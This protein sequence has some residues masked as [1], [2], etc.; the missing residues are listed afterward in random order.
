MGEGVVGG[1]LGRTNIWVP[2]KQFNCYKVD[3][4]GNIARL[5]VDQEFFLTIATGSQTK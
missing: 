2:L 4:V 1:E 3:M 5:Q